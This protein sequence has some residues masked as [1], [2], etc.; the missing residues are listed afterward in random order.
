M[1]C[2]LVR[3]GF[4]AFQLQIWCV[5]LITVINRKNWPLWFIAAVIFFTIM[6]WAIKITGGVVV[7]VSY[8]ISLQVHPHHACRS[9]GGTGMQSGRVFGYSQR[10][11][12]T[13]AGVPRHRRWGNMILSPGKPTRAERRAGVVARRRNRPLP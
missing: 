1:A 12:S 4:S 9:C 10:R 8:L 6:P 11:C 3:Q 7:L 5:I 13:C 2:P